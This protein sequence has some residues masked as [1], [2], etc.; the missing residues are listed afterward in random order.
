MCR[1]NRPDTW[2]HPTRRRLRRITLAAKGPSTHDGHDHPVS[3][4][5]QGAVDRVL[6]MAVLL[7]GDLGRNAPGANLVPYSVAVIALVGQHDLR[8]GV[9]L[10]YEIGE[11][12]AVIVGHFE[13]ARSGR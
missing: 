4:R 3:G 7:D 5:I 6:D 1:A 8:V 10:G 13:P 9:A 2:K 11:G 12:R